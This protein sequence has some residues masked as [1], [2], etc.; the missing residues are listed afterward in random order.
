MVKLAN[1]I[2][3]PK[4]TMH[5]V[6][7]RHDTLGLSVSWALSDALTHHYRH[8]SG[9]YS[10][11]DTNNIDIT[12]CLAAL[13]NVMLKRRGAGTMYHL[14]Q[15]IGASCR[16]GWQAWQDVPRRSFVKVDLLMGSRCRQTKRIYELFK[17]GGCPTLS[18]AYEWLE[19]KK[20]VLQTDPLATV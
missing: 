20:V 10:W 11:Y 3:F 9:P 19:G 1:R 2:C 18:R 7:Q 4:Q 8:G 16:I 15:S 14:W 17:W 12:L 13:W 6:Q 5:C